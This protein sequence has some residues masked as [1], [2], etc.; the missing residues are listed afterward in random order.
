MKGAKLIT[1]GVAI[2]IALVAVPVGVWAQGMW[3]SGG[4]W[5]SHGW[6]VRIRLM[7]VSQESPE[8]RSYRRGT[9]VDEESIQE[10]GGPCAP[11]S[12]E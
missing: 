5:G 3:G 1:V 8:F 7:Q 9:G 12:V 2:L 6:L 4:W 11:S 10:V